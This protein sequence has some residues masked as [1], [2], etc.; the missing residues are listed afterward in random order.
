MLQHLAN[1]FSSAISC[2]FFPVF[3]IGIEKNLIFAVEN[4]INDRVWLL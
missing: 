2:H 3:V 4:S 1:S